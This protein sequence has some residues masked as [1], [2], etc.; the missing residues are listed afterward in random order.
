VSI[1]ELHFNAD[2]TIKPVKITREG[3]AAD[4]LV[5]RERTA[6]ISTTS[7][8]RY[9]WV[10][11]TA[12]A[13]RRTYE[14]PDARMPIALHDSAVLSLLDIRRAEVRDGRNV[15]RAT[16]VVVLTAAAQERFAA[17]TRGHVGAQMAVVVDDRVVKVARIGGAITSLV[18]VITDMR[19]SDAEALVTRI[20]T[21]IGV[22][23]EH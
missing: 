4:T 18:P 10:D 2:G 14:D 9:Q 6:A 16:V 13:L 17:T 19:R 21:A 23:R 7:F 8:L 3:V 12:T 11:S 22:R 1:D 5:S 15:N 20:N